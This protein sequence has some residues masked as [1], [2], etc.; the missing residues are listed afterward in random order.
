MA[1]SILFIVVLFFA[2]RGF[3]LGFSGVI[4]R[5]SGFILG[6]YIAYS[7][8]DP[9][10]RLITE[11]ATV[12]IQPI[13][14]QV[15]SGTALFF[16]TFFITG[17]LVT[18]LFKLLT[19]L[20][21]ALKNLFEKNSTSSRV[22]GATTNGFIGVAIVLIGLWGYALA[23]DSKQPP[24]K[25][26][27]AANIFGDKLLAIAGSLSGIKNNSAPGWFNKQS[28]T[29]TAPTA[30]SPQTTRGSAEISSTADPQRQMKIE[31]ITELVNQ[32]TGSANTGIDLQKLLNNEKL[33]EL[34]K[35]PAMRKMAMDKLNDSPEK[36]ME[37]LNNPR[38][39]EL[40]D[41][42]NSSPTQ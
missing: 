12:N 23:T 39:R 42:L 35:D 21:P 11:S 3:F 30:S 32:Q 6:Y 19:K 36:M 37:A 41:K 2:L 5:V 15:I 25:L 16:T 34:L 22:I 13:V 24:D 18:A 20:I 28:K 14:L 31:T 33:Q 8:R 29:T 4:A 9:V 38:F 17:L 7:F 27:Q 1:S 26:Q 10:A 40:L